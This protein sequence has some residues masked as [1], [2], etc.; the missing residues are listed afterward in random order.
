MMVAIAVEMVSPMTEFFHCPTIP[1]PPWV[2]LFA[3]F[4]LL[5]GNGQVNLSR[6]IVARRSFWLIVAFC[7]VTFPHAFF[8]AL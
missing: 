5:L 6:F 7:L 8:T 3:L 4:V 1:L 2:D